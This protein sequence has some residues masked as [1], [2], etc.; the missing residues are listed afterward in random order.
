M[1][2]ATLKAADIWWAVLAPRLP[3]SLRVDANGNWRGAQWTGP[4]GRE[5][6]V[7]VRDSG[8][9]NACRVVW[10]RPDEKG[11]HEEPCMDFPELVDA[12]LAD[13]YLY[14]PF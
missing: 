10:R 3:E 7:D 6:A 11:W 9:P 13:D 1:A 8:T 14:Y 12:W 4:G 5:R 2:T